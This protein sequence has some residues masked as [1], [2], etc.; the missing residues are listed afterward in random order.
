MATNNNSS[1]ALGAGAV[2][3]SVMVEQGKI[4]AAKANIVA[5][6]KVLEQDIDSIGKAVDSLA[7]CWQSSTA[8]YYRDSVKAKI[9]DIKKE[10]T[11]LYNNL[12]KYF[13]SIVQ[14]YE[15]A[16]KAVTSNADLFK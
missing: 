13:A 2:T 8:T 6:S 7:D 5:Y 12:T 15:A 14:K 1:A 10:Q 4:I 16:E 9:N 3:A 11:T